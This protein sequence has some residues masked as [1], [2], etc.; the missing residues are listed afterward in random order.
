MTEPV[1]SATVTAAAAAAATAG[2]LSGL[3]VGVV[4]GAFAGAVFFVVSSTELTAKARCGFFIVSFAFG[5]L[6]AGVAA[7]LISALV[8]TKAGAPAALGALV[9]A[10]MAIKL[11]LGLTSK[12]MTG[13]LLSG[14]GG[15]I[16]SAVSA[17]PKEEK[18]E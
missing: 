17:K 4:I 14:L 18:G 6:A 15:L 12:N 8:P 2:W 3:D 5:I 7:D 10:A 11:L 9:A 13:R 1:S 16:A